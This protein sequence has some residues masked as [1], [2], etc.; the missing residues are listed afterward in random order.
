MWW[1][2]CTYVWG[3]GGIRWGGARCGLSE[4][5]GDPWPHFAQL[6]LLLAGS[7]TRI[8]QLADATRAHGMHAK[9]HAAIPPPSSATLASMRWIRASSCA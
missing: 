5:R 1:P 3:V 6:L 9:R 4:E 2:S 7:V 8:A